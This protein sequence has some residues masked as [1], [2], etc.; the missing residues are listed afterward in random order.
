MAMGAAALPELAPSF[1]G[2]AIVMPLISKEASAI[3][4]SR[5]RVRPHGPPGPK[6]RWGLRRKREPAL[7]LLRGESLDAVSQGTGSGVIPRSPE[8]RTSASRSF[9]PVGV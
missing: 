2:H 6:R 4:G 5:I 3:Y 1:L 9:L 8:I 7:C